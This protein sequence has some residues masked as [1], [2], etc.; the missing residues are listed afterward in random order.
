[1]MK[2]N[3][4]F[5]VT[6]IFENRYIICGRYNLFNNIDFMIGKPIYMDIDIMMDIANIVVNIKLYIYFYRSNRCF[7]GIER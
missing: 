7:L 4:D 5:M 6:Y 2:F 3:F 1:M